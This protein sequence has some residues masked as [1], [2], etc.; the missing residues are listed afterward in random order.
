MCI[1]VTLFQASFTLGASILTSLDTSKDQKSENYLSEL[2]GLSTLYS[3]LQSFQ[4]MLQPG[5]S[6]KMHLVSFT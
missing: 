4:V 1:I 3:S 2:N 5:S 6:L